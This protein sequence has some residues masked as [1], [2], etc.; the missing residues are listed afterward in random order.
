MMILKKRDAEDYLGMLQALL[1]RGLAWTRSPVSVLGKALYAAA[2]E[3]A[4][5]DAAAH[6]LMDESNPATAVE[7][8]A[9]WERVLGLPDGCLP[10]S[11]DLDDRRYAVLYYLTDAGR[12]DLAWWYALAADLGF[13]SAFAARTA[14]AAQRSEP[15][16]TQPILSEAKGGDISQTGEATASAPQD[17]GPSA[18]CIEEHWP[19][20]CGKSEVSDADLFSAEEEQTSGMGRCGPE[21]I[22]YWWNVIIRSGLFTFFRCGSLYPHD[23]ELVA[24][25]FRCGEGEPPE[26]LGVY[27]VIPSLGEKD[28]SWPPD[29]VQDLNGAVG[30]LAALECVFRRQKPAHTYLTFAY[31][32]L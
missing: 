18:I 2:E 16:T 26:R 7:G 22:R 12:S 31:E 11:E 20:V 32:E 24:T 23:N 14:A 30:S 28:A 27:T 4:R 5:I 21:E 6:L 1:P 9:D 8:L 3:L 13:Q 25:F 19:F 29:P 10:K 17:A 15:E